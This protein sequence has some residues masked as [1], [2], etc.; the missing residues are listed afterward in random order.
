MVFLEYDNLGI[1][2]RETAHASDPCECPRRI[3]CNAAHANTQHSFPS[4]SNRWV[5]IRSVWSVN[6]A[7]SLDV[8][9]SEQCFVSHILPCLL[10][11]RSYNQ[12]I[13]LRLC[14]LYVK[15]TADCNKTLKQS[16]YVM[17]W[18]LFWCYVFVCVW[19]G[20]QLW[21]YTYLLMYN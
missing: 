10:Y 6:D 15:M 9:F 5:I 4:G 18:V 2:V 16:E 13:A 21:L 17:V 14:N 1:N 7:Q 12:R 3:A 11:C 20:N 19:R 8:N